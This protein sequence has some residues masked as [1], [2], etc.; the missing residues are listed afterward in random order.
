[1]SRAHSLGRVAVGGLVAVALMVAFP[2]SAAPVTTPSCPETADEPP[3][4]AALAL[5]KVAQEK[6]AAEEWARASQF[7]REAVAE[8]P[9]CPTFV[10]ERLRWALWAVEAH[11]HEPGGD[12][13]EVLQFVDA[14]LSHE[15]TSPKVRETEDYRKLVRTYERLRGASSEPRADE[16]AQVVASRTPSGDRR[17]RDAGLGL[18][19][20]GSG[21]TVIGL[22]VGGVFTA[23]GSLLT[24]KLNSDGG[25]YTQLKDTG[26]SEQPEPQSE[27]AACAEL[28]SDIEDARAD[29]KS[30]NKA[31][32][33]GFSLM[34]TGGVAAFVGLGLLI[35]GKRRMRANARNV[36]VVPT[37]GGLLVRGQF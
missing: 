14:V 19:V 20:A 29:G 28:H 34:L 32:I 13:Q 11:E 36:R 35:H 24:K 31:G 25:L 33:A 16:G 27:P 2:A 10:D 1:M 17:L 3:P 7:F 22:F 9:S 12:R 6:R 18:S 5:K 8:L 23:K 26:C 21:L 37:F 30:A 4:R 15:Q